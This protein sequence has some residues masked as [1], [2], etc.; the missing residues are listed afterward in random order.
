M[1]PFINGA[2]D[3]AHPNGTGMNGTAAT[4]YDSSTV[5]HVWSEESIPPSEYRDRIEKV[6]N[7]LRSA[8]LAGLISF[9]DCWRGASTL[10]DHI[11][12]CFRTSLMG[13]INTFR[14]L[15]L[16]RVPASRRRIRYSKCD[17]LPRRG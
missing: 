7:G 1:S 15:L 8:G 10:N 6:R 11:R 12:L 3:T 2:A 14:H 16:H 4:A 5:K 17:L 9:G 13:M